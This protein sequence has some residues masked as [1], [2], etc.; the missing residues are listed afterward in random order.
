[1][2]FKNITMLDENMQIRSGMYL[3]TEGCFIT[4]LSDKAPTD[5]TR[6]GEE[7]GSA[8]GRLFIPAFYNAHAHNAMHLMRGYG[9]NLSLMSWLNDRIFPFEG[10]L[11]PDDIYYATLASCAEMLKFGIVGSND[12]YFFP[13]AAG[14]A[15]DESGLKANFSVTFTCFDDT[16]LAEMQ[17][18]KNALEL[19][20]QFGGF[21]EKR[22][23]PSMALHAEY[24]SNERFVRELAAAAAETGSAMHVHVS[25]TAGEVADCRQ[26]HENRSPVRYFA[27][28]GLFDM[29]TTAAHCVH[30]DD[31]D[32]AILREK[33]VSVASCPVSNLKLASGI[34]PA[35]KLMEAGVNVA[36][37]TDSV[38]SNNNLNMLEEVKLFAILH[39]GIGGNPTI[40][41][42]AQAICAATRAGAL[43][44]GRSD[45]GFIKEG[46]RADIAAVD[47]T[48]IHM[49]PAYNLLNNLVYSACG[50][51]IVM[52][53][54][55]GKLL[56]DNGEY[57]T[58]D[59]DKIICH[60]E[61]SRARIISEL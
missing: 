16:P 25:E 8:D 20:E 39:K 7:Y 53:M 50:S 10:R 52:T 57:K 43:S 2:L 49:Q 32:I 1:M 27:D 17:S 22:L 58:L 23:I 11:I 18:Y 3:G 30:I 60:T 54:A 13:S 48:G 61:K 35:V 44:Q 51:D 34:C 12:M 28:C 47:T 5:A 37:G 40:I 36:L 59:I 26:R 15:Y 4:Y 33:K 41:T 14:R 42:P 9:E 24:T 19:M 56:Y 55:D 31:D 45:C 29:P 38:A 46:F 6:Y 21:E